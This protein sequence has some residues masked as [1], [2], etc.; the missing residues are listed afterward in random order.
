MTCVLFYPRSGKLLQ[1]HSAGEQSQSSL[2]TSTDPPRKHAWLTATPALALAW[3]SWDAGTSDV[4]V[5]DRDIIR[6]SCCGVVCESLRGFAFQQDSSSEKGVLVLVAGSFCARGRSWG[7][8]MTANSRT[9]SSWCSLG[10]QGN[11]SVQCSRCCKAL[12]LSL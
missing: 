7:F 10:D 5:L 4:S 9:L 2:G 1:T 6:Q 3:T 8:G 12:S 11:D